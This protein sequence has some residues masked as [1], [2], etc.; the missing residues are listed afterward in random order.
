VEKSKKKKLWRKL[1]DYFLW[2][3]LCSTERQRDKDSR[4]AVNVLFCYSNWGFRVLQGR[5]HNHNLI[6]SQLSQL[7][8]TATDHSFIC[9]WFRLKYISEEQQQNLCP[10][11]LEL[12][13]KTDFAVSDAYSSRSQWTLAFVIPIY[14]KILSS[15][16]WWE[17]QSVFL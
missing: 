2:L 12:G 8:S 3:L 7:I 13:E 14:S 16:T 15:S 10:P 6:P 1:L 11:N 4:Q 5:Q 17:Q 9:R